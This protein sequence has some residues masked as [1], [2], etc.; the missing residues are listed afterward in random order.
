MRKAERENHMRGC[1]RGDRFDDQLRDVV[2]IGRISAVALLELRSPNWHRSEHT[3]R[4]RVLVPPG[5]HHVRADSEAALKIPFRYRRT[6]RRVSS[7]DRKN[8]DIAGKF[9]QRLA[10]KHRVVK[11]R[12]YDQKAA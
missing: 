10:R 1:I 5:L 7:K 9:E 8:A 11:V 12:R 6:L 2:V 4:L 3:Q